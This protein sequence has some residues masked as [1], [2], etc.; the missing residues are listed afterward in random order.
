MAGGGGE[1]RK[2][3]KTCNRNHVFNITFDRMAAG[4]TAVAKIPKF[5]L[6][7]VRPSGI[8]RPPNYG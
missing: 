2:N 4:W 5:G 1:K 7:R 8:H 3:S 6:A